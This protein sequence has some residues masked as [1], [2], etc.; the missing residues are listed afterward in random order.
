MNA[1]I[2]GCSVKNS[3]FI[4]GGSTGAYAGHVVAGDKG[5]VT[6]SDA[7]VEGCEIT[8]NDSNKNK[9]GIVLGTA[10]VGTTSITT[11]SLTGNKVNGVENNTTIYGRAV[12]GT[13]GKLTVNGEDK[14]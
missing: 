3:K 9:A 6:I 10:N 7:V 1:N 4:G 2:S 14:Q 11:S 12:L 8:T 5:V 13:T